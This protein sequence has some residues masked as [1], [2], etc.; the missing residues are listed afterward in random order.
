MAK[1][2]KPVKVFN[3]RKLSIYLNDCPEYKGKDLKALRQKYYE[4]MVVPL[5]VRFGRKYYDVTHKP[6]VYYELSI[7]RPYEYYHSKKEKNK[8]A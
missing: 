2:K 3:N 5:I 4:Q 6:F 8:T 7:D 1:I